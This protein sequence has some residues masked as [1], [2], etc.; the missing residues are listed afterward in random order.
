MLAGKGW[1]WRFQVVTPAM[2]VRHFQLK[3]YCRAGVW[4]QPPPG[5]RPVGPFAQ[6]TLVHKHYGAT[7]EAG[8]FF[9][10]GHRAAFFR[11]AAGSSRCVARPVGR[12]QRQPSERRIR[13]TWPG[14]NFW[15]V[16]R[17]TRSATLQPVQSPV[18][19]PRTLGPSLSSRCRVSSCAGC[20]RGL[21]P[22]RPACLRPAFPPLCHGPYPRR[23]DSRETPVYRA[24]SAWLATRSKSWAARNLRSSSRSKSRFAPRALPMRPRP[25]QG[26]KRVTT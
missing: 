13:H 19:Y 17:S 6:A 14:W 20:H 16:W 10:A 22:A 9:I 3:L 8:L 24:I 23:A 12:W 4:P 18:P 26:Q 25:P 21:H 2:A 1:K 5:A 15:P 11:W 7:L